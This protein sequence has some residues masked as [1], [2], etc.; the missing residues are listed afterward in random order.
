M[1]FTR[2]KGN[3][4]WSSLCPEYPT[5]NQH[6]IHFSCMYFLSPIFHLL[7]R[8][9]KERMSSS[10][11]P[12]QRNSPF[13]RQLTKCYVLLSDLG[14]QTV[15]IQIT[16]FNPNSCK[17]CGWCFPNPYKL[18]RYAGGCFHSPKP[19]NTWGWV[20]STPPYLATNVGGCLSIPQNLQDM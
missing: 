1:V 15:I 6:H 20:F 13:S 14:Q 10:W 18:A 16:C 7:K 9:H 2:A 8:I 19:C 12:H 17:I 11:K 3:L 5:I 4:G